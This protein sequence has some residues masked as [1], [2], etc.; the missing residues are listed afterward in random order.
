VTPVTRASDLGLLGEPVARALSELQPRLATCFDAE[1]Q[2]ERNDRDTGADA[3][4]VL[5]L[6]LESGEG[7]VRIVDAAVESRGAVGDGVVACAQQLLR[8]RTVA[9][10]GATS[11]SR[12]RLA[13]TLDHG[14]GRLR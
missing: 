4:A 13:F 10:P 7:E 14:G 9:V 11:G 3:A 5:M 1:P 8:E 12:H 6:H 2:D